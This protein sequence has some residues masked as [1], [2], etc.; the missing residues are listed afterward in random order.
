MR[1]IDVPNAV[2]RYLSG[3]SAEHIAQ[4]SGVSRNVIK[5]IIETAGVKRTNT[6]AQRAR[7]KTPEIDEAIICQQYIQGESEKTLADAY[8]I[9]RGTIRKILIA[10]K[11]DVRSIS[12]V[13]KLRMAKATPEERFALTKNAVAAV[14]GIPHR[15]K[16]REK[17]AATRQQRVCQASDYERRL[18]ALLSERRIETVPQMA[19]GRYNVDIAI[20]ESTI[21]VEVF[22][23]GWHGLGS[24][25]MRFYKRTDHLIDCGWLP[26]FVWVNHLYPV[27]HGAADY[28]VS[29]HEARCRGESTGSQEHVI[30]GNGHG[31]PV[32]KR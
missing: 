6:E 20:A 15:E 24:Q 21:A 31:G 30:W 10:Y 29:V 12:D 13:M 3:E 2:E 25:A 14:R 1:R 4:T 23:G 26:I 9:A 19:I 8:G 16:F 7:W 17:M 27:G 5:R 11:V 22:G 32:L 28:I 18:I